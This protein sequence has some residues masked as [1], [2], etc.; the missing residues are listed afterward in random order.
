MNGAHNYNIEEP[1]VQGPKQELSNY[2][3]VSDRR[4]VPSFSSTERGIER[5]YAVKTGEKHKCALRN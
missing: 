1:I 3:R 4:D 5:L 2:G